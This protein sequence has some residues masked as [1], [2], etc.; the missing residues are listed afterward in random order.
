MEGTAGPCCCALYFKVPCPRKPFSC[1]HTGMGAL[2]ERH[3]VVNTGPLEASL[4]NPSVLRC[5]SA[6][7]GL[8]IG[9]TEFLP[10]S[11]S[12]SLSHLNFLY[13]G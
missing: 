8:G 5:N 10:A 1:G 9:D 13:L 4:L 7:L 3:R 2:P 12:P 6:S 11:R